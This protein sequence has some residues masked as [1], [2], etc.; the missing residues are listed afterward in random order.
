MRIYFRFLERFQQTP[1]V[2]TSDQI[3][4]PDTSLSSPNAR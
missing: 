3:I 2:S 4:L 1:T